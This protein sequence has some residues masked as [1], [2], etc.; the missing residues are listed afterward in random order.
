MDVRSFADGPVTVRKPVSALHVQLE[1][2][3]PDH[4]HGLYPG[5]TC[6]DD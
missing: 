4:P 1:L 5:G 2:G 6:A 3:P